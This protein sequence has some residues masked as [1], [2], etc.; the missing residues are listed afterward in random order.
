MHRPCEMVEFLTRNM[1][2]F[3]SPET[4]PLNSPDLNPVD[5]SI[6]S[7]VEQHVYQA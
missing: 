4:W 2:S 1:P 6:W 3:I 7:V 5:Y